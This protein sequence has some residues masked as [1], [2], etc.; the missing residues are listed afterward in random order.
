M[1]LS[2]PTQTLSQLTTTTMECLTTTVDLNLDKLKL[3]MDTTPTEN[4]ML[5]FLMVA[6]R[7]SPTMLMAMVMLLMSNM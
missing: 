5:P 4:T 3:V 1:E 2:L 7:L 6:H